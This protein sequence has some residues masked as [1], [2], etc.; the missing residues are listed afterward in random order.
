MTSLLCKPLQVGVTVYHSFVFIQTTDCSCLFL[1][2]LGEFLRLRRGFK[3]TICKACW[4]KWST[5]LW[6]VEATASTGK[7]TAVALTAFLGYLCVYLY[8][9][10]CASIHYCFT[11]LQGHHVGYVDLS[12]HF[13]AFGTTW[14]NSWSLKMQLSQDALQNAFWI[15]CLKIYYLGSLTVLKK[16]YLCSY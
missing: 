7:L 13:Y 5:P 11:S 14:E 10:V 4:S 3:R 12:E 8:I 2:E 16:S 15:L 9:C 6:D 1:K